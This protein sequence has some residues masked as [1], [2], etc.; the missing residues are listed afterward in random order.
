MFTLW[1]RRGRDPL[2]R[3]T[4]VPEYE[5]PEALTPLQ[6][7]AILH[8]RVGN[9]AVSSEIIYLATRGYIKIT[10][11]HEKVLIFSHSDYQLTKLKDAEDLP[12]YDQ[13]L[14]S[15]LFGTGSE[16]KLSELKNK[17]YKSLP[18]IKKATMRSVISAG[19][20]A[21]DPT[22]VVLMYVLIG[23]GVVFVSFYLGAFSTLAVVSGA[24]SGGIIILFGLIMPKV[25]KEGAVI[26]ER[27][28][29]LNMY[30]TVAEKDRINFHNAPAKDPQLFEV[31]LPFAMVLGVEKEW[32]KQFEGIYMSQPNW[33]SDPS[34]SGFN[35]VF[36]TNDLH[37]FSTGAAST[38]ASAPGGGSGSGGGGSSGGG[39]G[40]GGGGS[41]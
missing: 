3:G 33:Y 25:T 41:W 21:Q 16:V 27:I 35:P 31:L 40:G 19:Y 30:M 17:F 39:M 15:G 10:K 26:R 36:F 34:M 28:K 1:W 38:L 23:A 18:K 37:S 4:I 6:M 9:S 7:Y 11:L 32:A 2:G 5:S 12:D 20:F 13:A 22:G 29:G 24:L 14:M 8:D